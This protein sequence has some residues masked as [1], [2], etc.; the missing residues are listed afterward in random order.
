M[1]RSVLAIPLIGTG[2]NPCQESGSRLLHASIQS[3]LDEV[4]CTLDPK[5]N[6]RKMNELRESIT[7]AP[8]FRLVT[9]KNRDGAVLSVPAD[10]WRA[11]IAGVTAKL[12]SVRLRMT[13]VSRPS[14]PGGGGGSSGRSSAR[15]CA[16]RRWLR[17]GCRSAAWFRRCRGLGP[18]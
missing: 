11:F 15:R 14:L 4:H 10:T 13:V 8:H 9:P 17:R 1:Q 2:L 6:P 7:G 16:V 3:V 12:N 18:G 5:R